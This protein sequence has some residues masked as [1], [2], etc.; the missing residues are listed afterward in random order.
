M[1]DMSI[2]KLIASIGIVLILCIVVFLVA[3]YI[4]RDQ[5]HWETPPVDVSEKL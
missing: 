1:E 3:K 2:G 5:I 4:V